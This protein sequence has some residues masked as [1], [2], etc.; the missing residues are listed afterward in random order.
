[1]RKLLVYLLAFGI[2][3][4]LNS[5]MKNAGNCS[6]DACATVAPVN[7]IQTIQNYILNNGLVATQHC[8][9]LFYRIENAGTGA[10]PGAC[11]NIGATYKASF[12]NGGVLEQQTSPITFS[13]GQSIRAWRI[14]VPLIKAG[15]RI[16]FY[17]PPSLAYGAQEVRDQQTG[18]VVIPANSYLSFEVDLVSV[19]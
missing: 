15:G 19:Q 2:C 10:V 1:M 3:F 12:M 13:L 5:C 16:V 7:E 8:S 17:V 4:Q 9:G 6:F 11:A 18:N 14:A